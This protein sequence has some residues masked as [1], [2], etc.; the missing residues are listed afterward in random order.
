MITASDTFSVYARLLALPLVLLALAGCGGGDDEPA[1][2]QPQKTGEADGLAAYEVESGGFTLSVPE[3]WKAATIDEILN[4]DALDE[5]RKEDPDLARQIEPFAQPG[6]PV[7]FVALDPDVQ[8]DFATNANVYVE[9]VPGGVT[10]DQYFEASL[11][12]LTDAF[13]AP[14]QER[15]T[16]PGGEAVRVSYEQEIASGRKVAIVQYILFEE[17]TGYVLTYTT[18]PDRSAEYAETFEASANTFE[19]L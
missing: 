12:K 18:L 19:L 5:I 6:S 11:Q 3:D 16:L 2:E 13:G 15:V 8:D 4:G 10:R 14:E 1:A 17:G 7:K 9:E